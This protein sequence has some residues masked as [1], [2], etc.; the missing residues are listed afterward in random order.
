MAT[1]SVNLIV[2]TTVATL[3]KADGVTIDPA[4]I[5]NVLQWVHDNIIV[6]IPS[7]ATIQLQNYTI[8]T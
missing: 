1:I 5:A 7:T 6:K 3:Y 2:S 8:A 4:V